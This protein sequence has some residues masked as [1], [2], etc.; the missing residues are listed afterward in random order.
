MLQIIKQQTAKRFVEQSL[1][2]VLLSTIKG[3]E[4]ILI[5]TAVNLNKFLTAIFISGASL[6]SFHL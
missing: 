1:E 3:A 4:K 6:C 5:S 2:A